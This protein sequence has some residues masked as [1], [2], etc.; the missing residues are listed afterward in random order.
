MSEQFVLRSTP[1]TLLTFQSIAPERR[2]NRRDNVRATLSLVRVR[3]NIGQVAKCV[4]STT[5]GERRSILTVARKD[6]GLS[7]ITPHT[8]DMSSSAIYLAMH[9][10]SPQLRT[11]RYT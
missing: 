6:I 4:L 5:V 1:R 11:D 7:H 9:D 2:S 10:I 8:N 3:T